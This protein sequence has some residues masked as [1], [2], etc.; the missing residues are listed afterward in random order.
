LELSLSLTQEDAVSESA[1]SLA[2]YLEGNSEKGTTDEVFEKESERVLRIEVDG[3]VWIKP[4]AAIAYRGDL[5]F[6]RL[7]TLQGGIPPGRMATRELVPLAR[8]V[9]KGRLYC[10]HRGYHLRILRLA[11]ET[12]HFAANELLAFEESLDYSIYL[13]EHKVG[14]VSGG[15][16]AVRLSGSG[17]LAFAVHGDPLTLRV[18]AQEPLLSDPHATLAWSAGLSPNLQ[19]DLSWR[20]LFKHGGGEPFQMRF[21]GE[22]Y[23]VVQPSEEPGLWEGRFH[24]IKK[25]VSTL[26]GALGL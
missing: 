9:G 11:G 10:A 14:L 20:S 13:V 6:E 3:G 1:Y 24:P 15:L 8:A 22:G 19:S 17:M 25:L 21:E 23:V 2:A 18:S 7:A 16:F 4:G 26:G 12:V 5:R